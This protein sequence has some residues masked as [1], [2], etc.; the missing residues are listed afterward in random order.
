M[1]KQ[2]LL[3]L[4]AALFGCKTKV[5]EPTYSIL[6]DTIPL[7]PDQS[8]FNHYNYDR[9][10]V[11]WMDTCG[12][13]GIIEGAE[14]NVPVIPS[15]DSTYQIKL[16]TFFIPSFK[17]SFSYSINSFDTVSIHDTIYLKKGY[18]NDVFQP[19]TDSVEEII[20]TPL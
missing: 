7:A 17:T 14:S 13:V 1:K 12:N 11:V 18:K 16:G 3:I 20:Y 19:S 5:K 8:L 4:V 9:F 2:I 10:V 15:I 6:I